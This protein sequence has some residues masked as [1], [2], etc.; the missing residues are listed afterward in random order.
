M[1]ELEAAKK[2]RELEPEFMLGPM[3]RGYD[4]K[5]YNYDDIQ[6]TLGNTFNPNY[7]DT[8]LPFYYNPSYSLPA[9]PE[10]EEPYEEDVG[11]LFWFW[12]TTTYT[13]YTTTTYKSSSTP[14]LV[15]FKIFINDKYEN[16]RH[17]LIIFILFFSI[18]S[19]V[20]LPVLMVN[21]EN[22]D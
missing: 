21:A 14:S 22:R 13:T 7:R 11:R 15:A 12:I 5:G 20:P 16:K 6:S 9:L 4:G 18:I 2:K 10:I 3:Y 19:V 17:E 1:E 8:E